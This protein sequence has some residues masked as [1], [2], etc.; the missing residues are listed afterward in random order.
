MPDNKL[1][2]DMEQGSTFQLSLTWKNNNGTLK[3]L[4]GYE[5]QMQIRPTYGSNTITESLSTA[6]GEIAIDD[7][8][9]IIVLTLPANRTSAIKVD[10]NNGMPPRSKYVY[11]LEVVDANNV[12]SKLMYGDVTVYGEVTR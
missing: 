6:N 5:A 9:S 3:D 4:T 8:N 7:Q 11:D 12:V 10:M 1:N 2:I